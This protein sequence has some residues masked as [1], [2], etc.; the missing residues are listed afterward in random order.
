MEEDKLCGSKMCRYRKSKEE[1]NVIK[2]GS[3]RLHGGLPAF[4]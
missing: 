4:I 3:P 2:L 1:M